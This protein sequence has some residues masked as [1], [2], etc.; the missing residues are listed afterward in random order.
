MGKFKVGRT[1]FVFIHSSTTPDSCVFHHIHETVIT[2]THFSPQGDKYT[3]PHITSSSSQLHFIRFVSLDANR[4]VAQLDVHAV[5]VLVLAVRNGEVAD[6]GEVD[7]D[8]VGVDGARGVSVT[9]EGVGGGLLVLVEVQV[10]GGAHL[11]VAAGR[12]ASE[13]VCQSSMARNKKAHHDFR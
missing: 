8:A 11:R 13:S 10:S 7:H 9:H 12:Q 5:V 3:N 2:G 4:L 1:A 6:S